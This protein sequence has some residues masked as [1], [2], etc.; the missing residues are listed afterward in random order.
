[1]DRIGEGRDEEF[2]LNDIHLT[3]LLLQVGRRH[4]CKFY[5][6]RFVVSL[7]FTNETRFHVRDNYY[8]CD[9]T[10]FLELRVDSQKYSLIFRR[11]LGIIFEIFFIE[12]E[13]RKLAKNLLFD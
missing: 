2:C 1:M 7:G 4:V 3:D 10:M 5:G 8:Y 11:I 12:V 9:E 6:L 13:E